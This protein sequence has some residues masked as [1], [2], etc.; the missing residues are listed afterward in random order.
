MTMWLLFPGSSAGSKAR[1]PGREISQSR[2]KN[3]LPDDNIGVGT[4]NPVIQEFPFLPG[5]SIFRLTEFTLARVP[6]INPIN[7]TGCPQFGTA[8]PE[9]REE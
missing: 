2:W 7:A 8:I 6:P 5:Y 9:C 3:R 4:K 1:I